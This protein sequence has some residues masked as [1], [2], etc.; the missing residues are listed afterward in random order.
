MAS[1]ANFLLCHVCLKARCSLPGHLR[2]KCMQHSTE[3]EI[4]VAVD[5]DKKN[6]IE[7]L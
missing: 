7:F 5:K 1:D 4:E 2:K 6:V 3:E